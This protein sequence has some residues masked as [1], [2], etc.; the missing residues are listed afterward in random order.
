MAIISSDRAWIH[1]NI[2]G[3]KCRAPPKPCAIEYLKPNGV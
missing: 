2:K 3:L 1:N